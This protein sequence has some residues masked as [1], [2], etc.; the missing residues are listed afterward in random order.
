MSTR[1]ARLGGSYIAYR[2]HGQ[3]P[4]EVILLLGL[5][6][7]VEATWDEPGLVRYLDRLASFARVTLMDFRGA[8]LSDALEG[9]VTL[10]GVGEVFGL[11]RY[12]V[13]GVRHMWGA[14]AP[15]TP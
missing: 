13:Q 3:G 5:S 10:E 14:R 2:C 9:A 12:G 7:H 4:R 8:G 15:G 11:K 6:T 1:Y